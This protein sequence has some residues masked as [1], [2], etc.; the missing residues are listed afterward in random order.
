MQWGCLALASTDPPLK[1]VCEVY[2]FLSLLLEIL[3]AVDCDFGPI[4]VEEIAIAPSTINMMTND[5]ANFSVGATLVGKGKFNGSL[6]HLVQDAVTAWLKR[7]AATIGLTPEAIAFL[8]SPLVNMILTALSVVAPDAVVLA[9]AARCTTEL[10]VDF[11][12][13]QLTKARI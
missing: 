12:T 2:D 6:K 4:A 1:A 9:A 8:T 13:G 7:K 11:A 5:T 10:P 3:Q